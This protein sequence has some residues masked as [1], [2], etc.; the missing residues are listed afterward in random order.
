MHAREARVKSLA[1][2]EQIGNWQYN[3][4]MSQ[5]AKAVER[6]EFEI[7]V[8]TLNDFTERMLKE[9]RYKIS[10]KRAIDTLGRTLLDTRF[11]IHK[12]ISW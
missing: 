8:E 6:G 4:I 5:I 12:I 9:E 1:K 3:S 2:A 11:I 10:D 7:T